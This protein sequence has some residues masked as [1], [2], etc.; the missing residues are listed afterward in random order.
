MWFSPELSWHIRKRLQH[1]SS[2]S[3]AV[4]SHVP[5]PPSPAAP[6]H[7]LTGGSSQLW[8][9]PGAAA[10]R[11]GLWGGKG[12]KPWSAA[13]LGHKLTPAH[14]ASYCNTTAGPTL[15]QLGWKRLRSEQ[16]RLP[17]FHCAMKSNRSSYPAG[18]AAAWSLHFFRSWCLTMKKGAPNPLPK[19]THI[20]ASS[21]HL[22][23][24][25]NGRFW[26]E[27]IENFSLCKAS[28]K[29]FL[30]H[31]EVVRTSEQNK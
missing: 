12:H 10:E 28:I 11:S 19:N 20:I 27:K 21:L 22:L 9:Q 23:S 4:T 26:R 13:A 16:D 31:L 14:C 30:T 25:E 8:A 5:A 2:S 24:T 3:C 1:H 15:Q 29:S 17:E 7:A 18:A 6:P